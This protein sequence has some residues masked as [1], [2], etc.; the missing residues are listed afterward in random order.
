MLRSLIGIARESL[1][2]YHGLLE[3][4]MQPL[5]HEAARLQALYQFVIRENES[6]PKP[7]YSIAIL[8]LM[9][10]EQAR[11]SAGL[12]FDYRSPS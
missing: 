7:L 8:K 6:L 2:P 11:C 1:G 4:L 12:R 10:H 3:R 5:S 9:K